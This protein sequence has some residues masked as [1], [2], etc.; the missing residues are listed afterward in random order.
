MRLYAGSINILYAGSLRKTHAET[1]QQIAARHGIPWVSGKRQPPSVF[2]YLHTIYKYT[3]IYI[4]NIYIYTHIVYTYTFE[5]SFEVKLSTIWTDEKHRWEESE[6]RREENRREEKR[7][8]KK[9]KEEERR[10]KRES[11]RR[12]KIQVRAKVGKPRNTVFF[13]YLW[14]RRVKK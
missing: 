2:I 12:K 7:R 1:A 8:E 14:L 11:I 9:K 10:S 13:P 4:Y 5:G 3:Y 6:K